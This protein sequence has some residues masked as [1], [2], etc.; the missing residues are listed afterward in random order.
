MMYVSMI[1]FSQKTY[2]LLQ[3]NHEDRA[4]LGF[5]RKMYE[6]QETFII[7]HTQVQKCWNSVL[8]Y[9]HRKLQCIIMRQGVKVIYSWKKKEKVMN[10]LV[11][12]E[13][14]VSSPLWF[15]HRFGSVATTSNS[16]A[17]FSCEMYIVSCLSICS[18]MSR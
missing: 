4:G 5:E 9:R 8:V 7:S 11:D 17:R 2:A 6:D 16:C 18:C 12:V 15:R 1:P 3:D 10:S 14:T 13:P